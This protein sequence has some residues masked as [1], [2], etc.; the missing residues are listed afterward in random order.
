MKLEKFLV[1]YFDVTFA[2]HAAASPI[3]FSSFSE[4]EL[5]FKKL[6]SHL[7]GN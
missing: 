4:N 7:F 6:L 3:Y 1:H 5:R 2:F